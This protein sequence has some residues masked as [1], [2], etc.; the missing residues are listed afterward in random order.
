MFKK[1]QSHNNLK[2][3]KRGNL[4]G[5]IT[6]NALKRDKIEKEIIEMRSLILI[7]NKNRIKNRPNLL[8]RKSNKIFLRPLKSKL[9]HKK[10]RKR[11]SQSRE[12]KRRK[13][14]KEKKELKRIKKKGKRR[15]RKKRRKRRLKK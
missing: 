1:T 4:V 7:K 6:T 2:M 8:L 13:L 15:I 10:K 12:E 5:N 9:I 11:N 3:R 14:M